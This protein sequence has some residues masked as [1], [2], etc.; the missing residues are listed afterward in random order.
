MTVK[1]VKVDPLVLRGEPFCYGTRLTVRQILEERRSGYDVARLLTDHPELRVMGLA[2]AYRYA[3]EHK[4]RYG[5]FFERDGSLMG[6][7]LT[8]KEAAMLP[9]PLRIAGVVVEKPKGRAKTPA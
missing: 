1:W 6:P 5:E 3:A 7:G 9:E 2:H 8:E 4:D